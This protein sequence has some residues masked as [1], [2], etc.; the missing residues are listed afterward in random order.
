M[1]TSCILR[2]P[3]VLKRLAISRSAFY[4]LIKSGK[5]NP[6]VSIGARSVGWLESDV[7]D[8]IANRIKNSRPESK[9]VAA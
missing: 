7:T 9:G 5:F 4:A 3:E 6:P 2:L 8:F 1:N